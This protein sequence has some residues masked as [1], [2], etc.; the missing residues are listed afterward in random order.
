MD[1]KVQIGKS[2]NAVSNRRLNLFEEPKIYNNEKN[3][4]QKSITGAK[5]YLDKE[6]PGI[7]DRNDTHIFGVEFNKEI[8]ESIK[9]GTSYEFL[10]RIL[11]LEFTLALK[12]M[13][14]I[15]LEGLTR[16]Q[17]LDSP[18][19]NGLYNAI[20]NF[21]KESGDTVLAMCEFI[22]N[23]I[24]GYTYYSSGNLYK[25]L[26]SVL[27]YQYIALFNERKD[28]ASVIAGVGKTGVYVKNKK[29]DA[30]VSVNVGV[31]KGPEMTIPFLFKSITALNNLTERMKK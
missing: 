9:T 7:H 2:K 14:E 20:D 15:H 18:N 31:I 29:G 21:R 19:G 27:S 6:G 26:N 10:N 28:D 23:N 1:D 5:E 24:D 22:R 12:V 16:L 17:V 11:N 3:L 4:V 25:D 8:L 30:K 13:T